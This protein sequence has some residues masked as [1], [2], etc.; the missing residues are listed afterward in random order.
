MIATCVVTHT[1][2]KKDK[3]YYMLSDEEKNKIRAEEIYREEIRN[4][5]STPGK[6]S[7][8]IERLR[9]YREQLLNDIIDEE[10]NYHTTITYLAAGALGLFLTI[11]EKLFNITE[12]NNKTVLFVSIGFLIFS[13]ILLIFSSILNLKSHE[14]LRD[15][16]DTMI[17]NGVYDKPKLNS[18]WE[19]NLSKTRKLFYFRFVCLLIGIVLEVCFIMSNDP[20]LKGKLKNNSQIEMK[21]NY[22]NPKNETNILIDSTNN[23]VSVHF[24]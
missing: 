15:L 6:E 12:A 16:T 14:S 23:K 5:I 9:I 17:V 13:I 24:K 1:L 2:A 18:L 10:K 8:D 3:K 21:I 11:N 22:N 19:K 20:S 4:S 7:Q